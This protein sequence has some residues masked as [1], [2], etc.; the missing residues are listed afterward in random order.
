MTKLAAALLLLGLDFYTYYYLATADVAPERTT[1]AEFPLELEDWRCANREKMSE[2]IEENLGVTDYLACNYQRAS[3]GA[4]VGVYIGYHASQV[5]REGGGSSEN[6]IH[7]PA[8]CLPGSGW[9]IIESERVEFDVPGL[10]G[11][12]SPVNR[13]VVA[14][15]D[16]RDLVYYWYQ[17]RGRV[18]AHDWRKIVDLFWDRATRSRTDGALVRFSAPLTRGD[19]GRGDEALRSLAAQVV[20]RLPAYVPN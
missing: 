11:G 5:R 4:V 15:G 2:E 17:E 18:I 14:R 1:L 8:H 10:P 3:T 9:D 12:P 6:I 16:E 7:P 13:L 20:P 19:D